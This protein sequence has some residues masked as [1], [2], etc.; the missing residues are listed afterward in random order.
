MSAAKA[1][2]S[3][4]APSVCVGDGSA[5]N[6]AGQYCVAEPLNFFHFANAPDWLY[7]LV[8]AKPEEEA[9]ANSGGNDGS[10]PAVIRSFPKTT[11]RVL[12][13]GQLHRLSKA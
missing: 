13:Q 3:I 6:V 10:H 4:V 12:A 1:V 2:T 7:E 5:K 11:E 8:L 9:R